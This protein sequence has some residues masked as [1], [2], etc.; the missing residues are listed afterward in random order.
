ML[1]GICFYKDGGIKSITLYPGELIQI[2]MPALGMIGVRQGF[3]LYEDGALQS[4]EPASP[5]KLQTPIGTLTAF[6]PN[7]NGVNAD[8]NSLTFD[9]Q[10]NLESL[11]TAGDRI[12]TFQ[13]G[14]A[15]LSFTPKIIYTPDGPAEIVPLRVRFHYGSHTVAITDGDGVTYD[16]S[17]DDT[18][19]VMADAAPELGCSG[20]DCSSCSLCG[21]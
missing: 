10:G 12:D 8:S 6:D 19:V 3:S 4:L 1:T 9:E 20:G 5:V 17:L 7:A 18:F 14:G 15:P 11:V 16:F 21:K 2:S 13:K